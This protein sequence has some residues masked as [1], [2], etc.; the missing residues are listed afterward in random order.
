MA[1]VLGVC[2]CIIW[3]LSDLQPRQHICFR[4]PGLYVHLTKLDHIHFDKR[5]QDN[6]P[7][8]HWL[9]DPR[10]HHRRTKAREV[11]DIVDRDQIVGSWNKADGKCNLPFQPLSLVFRQIN[12]FVDMP[13]VQSLS[14]HYNAFF[15]SLSL[16]NTKNNARK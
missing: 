8:F 14:L 9:V 2:W 16:T 15:S 12:Y 5:M 7:T 11:Q 4:V 3:L 6:Y 13:R 10:E 1:L